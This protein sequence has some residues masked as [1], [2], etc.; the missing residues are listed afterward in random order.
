MT[1]RLPKRMK[2]P[3]RWP[4]RPSGAVDCSRVNLT[5]GNPFVIGVHG[6]RDAV[7]ARFRAWQLDRLSEPEVRITAKG[8]RRVFW[9]Q[10]AETLDE[11]A[12]AEWL[13]CY[14][15]P[16]EPCHCDVYLELLANRPPHLRSD[17]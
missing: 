10:T 6:D 9:P 8:T 15:K 16:D 14:C 3:Y 12:G 7:I 11:L 1:D 13:A 17:Q 2:R 5:Y 4:N